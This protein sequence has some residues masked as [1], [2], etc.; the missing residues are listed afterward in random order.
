MNPIARY[1]FLLALV[2]LQGCSTV[3][4]SDKGKKIVELEGSVPANCTKLKRI[5]ISTTQ[6]LAPADRMKSAKNDAANEAAAGGATH[7]KVVPADP[8][9]KKSDSVFSP[10]EL[11]VD[12][13][14]C[15]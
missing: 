1:S 15:R 14:R 5:K 4:L 10:D 11:T 6:G 8:A 9:K 7:M 2:G 13:F 3:P 12:A